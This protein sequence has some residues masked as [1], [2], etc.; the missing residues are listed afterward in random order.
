MKKHQLLLISLFAI[1]FIT[2]CNNKG[3]GEK[4][5][6]ECYS[7]CTH[8]SHG[9]LSDVELFEYN[10]QHQVKKITGSHYI[11]DKV[12]INS[13]QTIEYNSNQLKSKEIY[14]QEKDGT[15]Q[16]ERTTTYTYDDHL[17]LILE[18]KTT[19]DGEETYIDKD[20]TDFV[21]DTKGNILKKVLYYFDDDFIFDE[22]HAYTYDDKNRM[23]SETIYES[24]EADRVP[25]NEYVY[26]YEN[27]NPIFKTKAWTTYNTETKKKEN[28][29]IYTNTFNE[30]QQV[31]KETI[32]GYKGEEEIPEGTIEINMKYDEYGNLYTQD[33]Y[34]FT[35]SEGETKIEYV[36]ETV[37][38]YYNGNPDKPTLYLASSEV[39]GFGL[40]RFLV[41][42]HTYD[43]H[44]RKTFFQQN[45]YDGSKTSNDVYTYEYDQLIP[46]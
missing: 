8:L 27:N 11:N 10:E 20:K 25:D 41:E 34:R 28:L 1:P 29:S 15:V 43:E 44:G 33:G 18:E 4:E 9:K 19:I 24:N 40:P 38:L 17:N 39:K 13:T 14:I 16:S 22:E 37:N 12:D 6:L 30:K 45:K 5:Y 32:E 46:A 36:L 35:P 23:L 42:Q 31:I 26:T 7:K 2:S 21:Y 3:S